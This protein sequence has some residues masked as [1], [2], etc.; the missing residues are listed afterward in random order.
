MQPSAISSL[1]ASVPDL[2]LRGTSRFKS[3][4]LRNPF[5]VSGQHSADFRLQLVRAG[6][7]GL[8]SRFHG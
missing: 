2:A 8:D 6:H 7:A 5:R 4:F 1:R 3:P